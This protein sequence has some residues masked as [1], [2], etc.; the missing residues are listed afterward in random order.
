MV[1]PSNIKT[2][3]VPF[4]SSTFPGPSG[5]QILHQMFWLNFVLKNPLTAGGKYSSDLSFVGTVVFLRKFFSVNSPWFLT[6]FIM[7]YLYSVDVLSICNLNY[8]NLNHLIS[9]LI[10]SIFKYLLWLPFFIF[11]F[12]SV[13][14]TEIQSSE[15]HRL[16]PALLGSSN[17]NSLKNHTSL[18][19]LPSCRKTI[20]GLYSYYH[21]Y[22]FYFL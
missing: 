16:S 12:S 19:F 20:S 4:L 14:H 21:I 5:I 17:I 7:V 3:K 8:S 1:L 15:P 13:I 2:S 6:I 9:F 10:H 11:L 22:Y 18:W